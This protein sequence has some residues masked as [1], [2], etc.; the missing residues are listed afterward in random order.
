MVAP[1]QD[2]QK[3]EPNPI[4]GLGSVAAVEEGHLQTCKLA[5]IENSLTVDN[6]KNNR[7]AKRQQ[8]VGWLVSW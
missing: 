8:L 6:G 2:R 7:K 5:A 3:Q 4:G 1:H